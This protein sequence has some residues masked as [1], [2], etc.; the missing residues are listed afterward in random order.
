METFSFKKDGKKS[1][2][3]SVMSDSLQ[4]CGLKPARL[5]GP[6]NFPGKNTGVGCYFLLQRILPTQELNPASKKISVDYTW[7]KA[8]IKDMEIS[9]LKDEEMLWLEAEKNGVKETGKLHL[10]REMNEY[11]VYIGQERCCPE[12]EDV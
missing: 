3:P 6:W 11:G 10:S 5:L 9:V 12:N 4:P 2:S 1:V 8:V 7:S